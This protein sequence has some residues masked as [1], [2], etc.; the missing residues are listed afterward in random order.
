M[1]ARFTEHGCEFRLLLS[2]FSS[3][4]AHFEERL[5]L[6]FKQSICGSKREDPK[7]LVGK[8]LA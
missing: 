2:Y 1:E 3:Y 8:V 6:G 7:E 4:K 5:K